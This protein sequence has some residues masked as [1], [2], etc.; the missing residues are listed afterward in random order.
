MFII[1]K[2]TNSKFCKILLEKYFFEIFFSFGKT[3]QIVIIFFH[4]FKIY[5]RILEL[6][7]FQKGNFGNTSK[8]ILLLVCN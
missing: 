7:V 6:E 8:L 3:L 1:R 4:L 2:Y 5:L